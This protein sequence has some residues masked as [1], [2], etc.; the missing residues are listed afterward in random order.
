MPFTLNPRK[1]AA[2][3]MLV[4]TLNMISTGMAATGNS[5]ESLKAGISQLLGLEENRDATTADDM[6]DFKPPKHSFIDYATYFGI[7]AFPP[8]L[9]LLS[10]L[11][12]HKTFQHLP[13]IYIDVPVPPDNSVLHPAFQA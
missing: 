6:S 13:L 1:I 8:Y 12:P 7:V 11:R 5:C 10:V 3:L 2:V 4:L 9:P